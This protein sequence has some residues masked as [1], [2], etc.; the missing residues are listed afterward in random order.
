DA[1]EEVL[2]VAVGLEADQVGAQHAR[3]QL[4]APRADAE[5]RR[6]WEGQVPEETHTHRRAGGAQET[7]DEAEMEVV[8]P[9]EVPGTRLRPHGGREAL[10]RLLVCRP[11]RG[12]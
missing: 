2:R 3:E 11:E 9:D 8:D 6:R 4:R 1:V 5:H 12:L 7:G 10:V